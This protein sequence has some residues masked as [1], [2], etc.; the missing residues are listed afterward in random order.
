MKIKSK[1]VYIHRMTLHKLKIQYSDQILGYTWAIINPMV[2]VICYWYF[3]QVGLRGG[4][5]IND[6]NYILWLFPGVLV[7]RCISALITNAPTI[8]QKNKILV[9]TIKF[10]VH[11]IPIIE[12]LKEIYVHVIVMFVMFGLYAIIG[13][14]VE[15]TS[16]G[17]P[18]VYYINFIYYWL[19][20]IWFGIT[21]SL[22]LGP[23]GLLIKD[24]KNFI[25]AI[26]QPVFWISPVLYPVE[27][28]LRPL[29]EKLEIM[30]NPIYFFIFGYRETMVYKSFFY[31]HFKYNLYF[32]VTLLCVNIISVVIWKKF[33]PYLSDLY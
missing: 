14:T 10:P 8:L 24:T 32:T 4:S 33:R 2:Y 30:F 9:Y 12:V 15:G 5:N 26:M 18:S 19:M 20:L 7:Y 31:E 16:V 29:V 28:G 3:F 22:L 11:W 13:Y 17:L 6:H 1:L 27:H 21:I 25:S 23:I